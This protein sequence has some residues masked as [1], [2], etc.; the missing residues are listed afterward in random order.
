M[1]AAR[2]FSGSGGDSGDGEGGG[3]GGKGDGG[4]GSDAATQRATR[5]Y[6][7]AASEDVAIT[8]VELLAADGRTDG[9]AATKRPSRYTYVACRS[10]F[11][12]R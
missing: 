7:P 5:A 11:H 2:R 8:L 12:W 4:G 3:K 6:T 10:S 1:V 9:T